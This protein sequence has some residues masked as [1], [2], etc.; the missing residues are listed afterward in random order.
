MNYN[1]S[2]KKIENSSELMR[3]AWIEKKKLKYGLMTI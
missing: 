3:V 2:I 1:S